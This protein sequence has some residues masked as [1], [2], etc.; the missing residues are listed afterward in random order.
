MSD[1]R[2][3]VGVVSE[4]PLRELPVGASISLTPVVFGSTDAK[5]VPEGVINWDFFDGALLMVGATE[6]STGEVRLEGTGVLIAP[7][8]AVTATHTFRRYLP[9]V[10]AGRLS[11][12]CFGVR[13]GSLDVWF[14][15]SISYAD[16]DDLA[17]LS[18][19]LRSPIS[20]AWR[21]T[22]LPI[23]TR[24]PRQGEN[25]TLLGFRMPHIERTATGFSATG[26]L[27]AAAGPVVEVYWPQRDRSMPY[28]CIQID[29]GSV[30]AMSGGPVLDADGQ[31]IGVTGRGF[32]TEAGDGPT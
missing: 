9:Y 3:V 19:E 4:D 10:S 26:E 24:T 18:L 5:K 2:N 12:A 22:S 32:N 14:I 17:F 23:T 20:D 31:L 13:P 30:G 16:G 11:L 15:R 28:P 8:L 6:P 25:L 7:G 1:D 29:C 21:F 27:Y